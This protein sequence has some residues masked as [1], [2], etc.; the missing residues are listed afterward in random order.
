M[1]IHVSVLHHDYPTRI[2]DLVER[3]LIGLERFNDRLISVRAVLEKVRDTHRVEIIA[4]VGHGSVMVAQ[5]STGTFM[6]SLDEALTKI[7]TQVKR[8]HDKSRIERRRRNREQ[9][10]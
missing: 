5:A 8:H 4:K 10:A 9:S 2:H 1:H 7:G 6:A 3:K